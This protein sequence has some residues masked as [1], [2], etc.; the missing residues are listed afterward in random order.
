MKQKPD[1][2]KPLIGILANLLTV[3]EG[4]FPGQ[5]R[6]YVNREYV[7]S[8]VKA[9]AVP[10]LLP[11]LTDEE[12]IYTQVGLVDG[13][14]LSGGYDI[15]P[16]F[17]GEEPHKLL[18]FVCPER[19]EYE[20]KVTKIAYELHKPLLGIC[21]GLQLINV[22]FGGTLYQDLSQCQP[23]SELQHSQKAN[24]YV[25]SHT[26]DIAHHTQ[27][28]RIFG[29]ES[30]RTN[31]FHHQAIKKIAPGCIV[32][33]TARDG[34]IEGIERIDR[35]FIIGVQWHPEMMICKHVEMLKLFQAFVLAA[36]SY[37]SQNK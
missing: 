29:K 37:R 28:Y 20:I 3:Q 5:E 17:Y 30:I 1:T 16:L 13:I 11:I 32:S 24:M 25:A 27:L 8:L 21:R 2:M 34:I 4:L 7:D 31:S 23:K 26:V 6:V 12:A 35:S 18:D 19:D 9:G 10:V 14:L 15:H 22:A 33:A 36:Q